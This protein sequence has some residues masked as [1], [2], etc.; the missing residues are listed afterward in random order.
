[1]IARI[2]RINNRKFTAY[3]LLTNSEI[4][5]IQKGEVI[6]AN[7][8]G[9]NIKICPIEFYNKETKRKENIM[10]KRKNRKSSYMK[11]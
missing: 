7:F 4:K 5:K 8:K 6:D 10:G 3:L 2:L 11:M 1:M 9:G